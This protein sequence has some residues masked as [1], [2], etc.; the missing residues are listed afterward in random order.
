VAGGGTSGIV[1][2]SLFVGGGIGLHC[3]LK[4]VVLCGNAGVRRYGVVVVDDIP[5]HSPS[6]DIAFPCA[7]CRS[8][9]ALLVQTLM[10][11]PMVVVISVLGEHSL[12]A[13]RIQNRQAV[14]APLSHRAHPSL[15]DGIGIRCP[16]GRQ[17]DLRTLGPEHSVEAAGELRSLCKMT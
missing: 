2:P 13:A 15:G 5:K 4:E 9:R 16:V 6:M 1:L 8:C 14:Q 10:G 3:I 12:E 11:P 17:E 7:L